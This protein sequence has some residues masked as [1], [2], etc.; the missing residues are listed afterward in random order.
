MNEHRN[1]KVEYVGDG[2]FNRYSARLQGEPLPWVSAS[3]CHGIKQIEIDP[4]LSEEQTDPAHYTVRLYF[5]D[6]DNDQPGARLF[7]VS[8]QG[9]EVL[10]NFDIAREAGGRDQTVVKEFSGIPVSESLII[11]F[12]GQ[13]KPDADPQSMPL[14]NGVEL[15]RDP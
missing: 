1:I 3:G 10:H 8:L 5:C 6:P 13:L 14:L 15:I 4:N 11:S 9:E 12:E 2:L 7:N